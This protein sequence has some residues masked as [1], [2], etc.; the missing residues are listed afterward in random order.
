[1]GLLCPM[2]FGRNVCVGKALALLV[3]SSVSYT[4]LQMYK[5]SELSSHQG[6][7]H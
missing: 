7:W 6:A 1:M 5:A 3:Q 4:F 2:D